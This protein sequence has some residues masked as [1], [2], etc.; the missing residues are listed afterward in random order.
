MEP[1]R[2]SNVI[3]HLT[4]EPPQERKKRHI[5]NRAVYNDWSLYSFV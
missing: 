2:Y 1:K 4:E 3:A 5:R